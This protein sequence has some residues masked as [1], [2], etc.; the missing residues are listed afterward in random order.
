MKGQYRLN[1]TEHLKIIDAWEWAG[2]Y[3]WGI[4]PT[5]SSF[6][7]W[8]A[9]IYDSNCWDD[10]L[11]GWIP[12]GHS[13]CT[14]LSG[15]HSYKSVLIFKKN[16]ETS[17][18]SNLMNANEG[19]YSV[20]A[21][22]PVA[23]NSIVTYVPVKPGYTKEWVR[24]LA[25]N[26]GMSGDIRETEDAFYAG[27]ADAQ[28]YYFEVR[29][30]TSTIAFQ[31]YNGRSG[32]PQSKSS[33]IAAVDSFL[34]KNDLLPQDTLKPEVLN[35]F[36]ESILPSGT[37]H[38]DWKTNIVTY[39]QRIDGLPVFNAQFTVE[40]DSENRVIGLWRNWQDY[41]LYQEIT[42]KSPDVAFTEF[43]VRHDSD[44]KIKTDKTKVTDV[45]LGYVMQPSA[46][47]KR[48]LE[49]AYIFEGDDQIGNSNKSFEPVTIDAKQKV[50]RTY[51][52]S[53]GRR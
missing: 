20:Q 6:D 26:L 12:E 27:D 5:T 10:Y 14:S 36:A 44:K 52:I 37:R 29:R 42:V 15:T 40:V 23:N 32:L 24:S 1:Q 11:L 35:N 48:I 34:R 22:V 47:G 8:N 50:T 33:S 41:Q 2:K 31:K 49:P 19:S 7:V 30:D 53:K 21:S 17:G 13:V 38:L 18:S 46:D 45:S 9:A 3:T 43:S 4:E 25:K 51:D 16:S 28:H 39:P